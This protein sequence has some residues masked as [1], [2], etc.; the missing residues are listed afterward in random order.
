MYSAG[1]PSEGSNFQP[2]EFAKGAVVLY[3]AYA[4]AKKADRL[5]SFVYGLLPLLLVVGCVVVLIALEPDLGGA[6]FMQSPFSRRAFCCWRAWSASGRTG[7][8]RAAV[9]QLRGP[10]CGIPD[11]PFIDVSGPVGGFAGGGLSAQPIPPGL[12][13]RRESLGSDSER[14]ARRCFICQ[15][16]TRTLFSL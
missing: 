9:P 1:Y 12:W 14:V 3:L 4:L 15:R 2:S 7:R 10:E 8:R 6:V 16:P 5:H 11:G 13:G